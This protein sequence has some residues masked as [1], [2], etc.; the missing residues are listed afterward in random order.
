MGD[1]GVSLIE[2]G[3]SQHLEVFEDSGVNLRSIAELNEDGLKELGVKLGNRLLMQR[4]T[5]EQAPDKLMRAAASSL[6]SDAVPSTE[7]SH[8][9]ET[10]TEAAN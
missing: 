4:A 6:R 3:L 5:S 7:L 10:C 1:L 9:L 8:G 2:I